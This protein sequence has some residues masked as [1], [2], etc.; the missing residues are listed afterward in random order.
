MRGSREILMPVAVYQED[1]VVFWNLNRKGLSISA[2]RNDTRREVR[3]DSQTEGGI[4]TDC[5]SDRVHI[6]PRLAEFQLEVGPNRLG[7][8]D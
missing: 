8:G 3:S 7:L 4:L 1:I 5:Y 6:V 2:G